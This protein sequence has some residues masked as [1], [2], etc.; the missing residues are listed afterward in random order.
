MSQHF[1]DND[2]DL[3]QQVAKGD[4]SAFA[5][6]FHRYT[7]KIYPFILKLAKNEHDAREVLQETFLKIWV[8][9]EKLSAV[10]NPSAWIYRVA[11]NSCVNHLRSVGRRRKLSQALE[12]SSEGPSTDHPELETEAKQLQGFISQA[13]NDLPER[14]QLIYRMR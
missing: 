2:K 10:E 9:R 3:L 8:H 14:R 6:L 13:V 11:S 7:P 1:T 4:E 5:E 12:F